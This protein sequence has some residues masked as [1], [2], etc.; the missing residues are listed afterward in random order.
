MKATLRL[1]LHTD[2]ATNY[3]LTETLRQST[4]CFNAVCRYGWEN[5][6]R[7]GVCLHQAT[8]N[9]LRK[10]YDDMPSQLVAS[11][12]MKATEAL[13]SVQERKKQGRTVSCP[14]S[15]CCPIRYDAR[16]YW[17]KL[18][19]GRA[20]LAYKAERKGILLV[21]VDPRHSS[22]TCSKCGHCE[23]RNRKSQS[24]FC[25]QSC[26]YEVNADYN[27]AQNLR[28]RGKSSLVR[29]LPD[30]LSQPTVLSSP[31][32]QAREKAPYDGSRGEPQRAA[33]PQALAGGI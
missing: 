7:N 3:T 18:E 32:A 30:S 11:A 8:Y 23:K 2:P 27:A 31:L 9:H 16:S 10:R 33:S 26:G 6:E 4:A 25:C 15:D 12:R 21:R 24:L 5:N 14:H 19:E 13:K 22:R 28:Q 17:V 29:L 20:S 1:K